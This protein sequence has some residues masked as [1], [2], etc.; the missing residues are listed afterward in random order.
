MGYPASGLEGLYRN[1]REDAQKFLNHRHGKNFWVF[2]FCPV[3]ENSYPASVFDGRVSRYPFPDH[4]APPLA[5]LPLAAREM[6]AWLDG[7]SERV[8]VVHCKAGK[9]RS[10]TLACAYLLSLE[11]T[12]K[13]PRLERNYTAKEWA[14]VRADELMQAMPTDDISEDLSD[15]KLDGQ[16]VDIITEP[17]SSKRASIAD[18]PAVIASPQPIRISTP[19]PP[20]TSLSGPLKQVLDLHTSQRMKTPASPDPSGKMKQGVSIPSQRRWLYYWS[21]LMAHQGPVDYWPLHPAPDASRPK[22]RITQIKIRMKEIVGVKMNLV[23]AANIV[24]ERT[25]AAKAKADGSGHVWASLA[26]YDDELVEELEGWER[27]TRNENGHMGRRQ[28]GS[29]HG[30]GE[31]LTDLF[32]DE[33]WDHGKMVRSFARM[34]ALGESAVQREPS[35]KDG[36]I[37]AYTLCALSDDNWIDIGSGVDNKENA[38]KAPVAKAAGSAPSETNSIADAASIQAINPDAGVVVDANREVRLKLYMGQVFMGWI[39]FIPAFHIPPALSLSSAPTKIL[40]TRKEIDF[41][42]GIGAALIDVEIA[43]SSCS[44]SEEEIVQ[45]PA[46]Q[47]SQESREGDGISEP[48]GFVATVEAATAAATVAGGLSEVVDAKQAAEVE[49]VR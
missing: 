31:D 14:H 8:I 16:P 15:K 19:P 9:G 33:R 21:L 17:A 29:E 6:R 34:G 38:E 12:P 30:D 39:W 11:G 23:R 4:H 18:S 36:K 7:S 42:L 32:G 26:R 40:L 20:T 22:V 24:L 49:M 43:I 28:R 10:G 2:N 44:N 1:R 41:P 47:T 25:Q 37:T 35:G 48:A 27:R 46:R 3:K 5:I 45:P 13:P